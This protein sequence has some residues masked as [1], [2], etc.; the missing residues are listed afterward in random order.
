[1]PNYSHSYLNGFGD[2]S[3]P[4]DFVD[5]TQ[6]YADPYVQPYIQ[7]TTNTSSVGGFDW[8]TN[9]SSWL[10]LAPNLISSIKGQPYGSTPYGQQGGAGGFNLTGSSLLGGGSL[11]ISS[12][13]LL[14]LGLG[15]VVI[16]MMKK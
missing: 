11:G 9:I 15:V 13:T 4:L 6:T 12:S 8:G 10:K 14:L 5:A 3:N 16:F 7:P 2:P 1:M